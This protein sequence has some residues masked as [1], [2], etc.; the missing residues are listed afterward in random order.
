MI[1]IRKIGIFFSA[2]LLAIYGA[3]IGL[4]LGIIY[5]FGGAVIDILVSFDWITSSET[6]GVSSGTA[7]AFFA[8]LGM[9][10]IF[11]VLGFLLGIIGAL[12]YNST[13]KWFGGLDWTKN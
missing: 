9:P 11:A 5:S 3:G 10:I 12:F 7:L 13:S 6:T 1:K 2:K 4:I 8:L